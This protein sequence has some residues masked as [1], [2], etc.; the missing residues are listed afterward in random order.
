MDPSLASL[1]CAC[2]I[3]GLFYLER[4]SSVRPSK[5]LWLPV[6]YLWIIGSRPVSAWLGI[7]PP[8]GTNVQLD[9]SPIDALV[10]QILLVAGV[11][12][13]VRRGKQPRSLLAANWPILV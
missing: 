1:I 5:A 3:A 12:V 2:G 9:G 7:N 6:V 10:F 4:D 8:S 13:L 11:I